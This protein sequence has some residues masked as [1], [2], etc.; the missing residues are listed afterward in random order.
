M[1]NNKQVIMLM[2]MQQNCPL[3]ENP[4]DLSKSYASGPSASLSTLYF[5]P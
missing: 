3:D 2:N 5:S 4:L 1:L